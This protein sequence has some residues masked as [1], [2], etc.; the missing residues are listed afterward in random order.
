MCKIVL[1]DFV[2]HRNYKIITYSVLK[3]QFCFH[4]QVEKRGENTIPICLASW[5]SWPGQGVR[6]AQT[7]WPNR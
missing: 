5:L 1:L 6:L 2:H 4:L 3:A 7:T